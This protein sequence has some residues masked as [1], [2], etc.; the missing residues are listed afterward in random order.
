MTGKTIK[1]LTD[2]YQASVRAE[3]LKLRDQGMTMEAI[4]SQYGGMSRSAV[5]SF[6]K[7]YYR[8]G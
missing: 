6:L 1:Q 2:E 7:G 3:M 5:N 8:K 4:G